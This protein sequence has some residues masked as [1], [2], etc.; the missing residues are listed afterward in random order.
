MKVFPSKFAAR[1]SCAVMTI[2]IFPTSAFA[3]E[4]DRQISAWESS[5]SI[6]RNDIVT[7][8]VARG[9]D[10]LDS[11]TSTSSIKES[12]LGRLTPRTLAEL[13]R[14]IPGIRVEASN[15]EG[16]NNYAVRGLPLVGEGAKYVQIQE[17]G[18]PVLEFGDILSSVAD[19]FVRADF[20]VSQVESI[21]GGSSS[22]FASNAPGGVINL[23]SK[24][25]DVQ[26]GSIQQTVGIDYGN[27]R[28][29]FDYGSNLGDGWRFHVGGFYRGG[30]GPRKTGLASYRGGQAKINI[31]K[32]FTDGYV[33]VYAKFL[34]D[35][36][37][38]YYFH[39][40]AVGGTNSEPIYSTVNNF[41]ALHNSVVSP[42]IGL[43]LGLDSKGSVIS[44]DFRDGARAKAATLGFEAQVKL[45]DW[46]VTD[47]FRYSA[48]SSAHSNL[49]TASAAPA[50]S[51]A[52]AIG[53][54]GA[55]LTYASGPL[56]GQP[57]NSTRGSGLLALSVGAA[58]DNPDLNYVT[59]DLRISRVWNVAGGDLTTT[60]GL[61][62][63]NQNLEQEANAT[64]FIHDVVDNGQ[65]SLININTSGGT[66]VTQ[67][68]VL[69]FGS[70]AP[71][72]RVN[73]NVSYTITAPFGSFNFHKGRFA[74]GGSA[75]VDTGK[76]RGSVIND[77]GTRV[78]DLNG[79]GVI[80]L[81]EMAVTYVPVGEMNPVRYN[82]SYLSYSLGI[83]IRVSEPFAMFAR[84]SRGSRAGAE[85]IL[86]NSLSPTSG[87]LINRQAAFDP[88]KQA[89][90]GL[91]FRNG[92]LTLNLTGFYAKSDET[93][94]QAKTDPAT[95]LI[96]YGAVSRSYKA[97]G[98][99]FEGALR[100]GA[101][102]ITAGA[103]WT[104]AEII[105]AED[106]LLSGKTPRHQPA[107][108][109]QLTPQYDT[110]SF[111]FGANVI[112]TTGSFSQDV[113]QLK[114]PGY[115]TVGLFT[116]YRPIE[117]VEVSLNVSN[118][119]DKLAITDV[120]EGTI[121]SS[122]VAMA[123]TLYGRTTSASVRF[124]F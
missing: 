84:Y 36:F 108:L 47:R 114:M 15:G 78:Y 1:A 49:F 118:L 52:A 109:Y 38:A 81:P 16:N 62:R 14:T 28:T 8:G 76:V 112:G 42:F 93:S 23:I 26:G 89:E 53:G 25:G 22:T 80:S 27:Y 68:G 2:V 57:F 107:L 35:R 17:D 6:D 88:V 98:L 77:T 66:A 24:T 85:K 79:D 43:G 86:I 56:S 115:A 32:Q 30:E 46:I 7:T 54:P 3:A 41:S 100:R 18:L 5:R 45:G 90:V 55:Q 34:D 12:Q 51:F 21:R 40:I 87:N 113:N 39:P 50:A 73:S 69:I 72:S 82:Y 13:F 64:T 19:V 105:K 83:N 110:H 117:K 60:A 61:Y 95:Q 92:G 63:S 104:K 29:D 120:L 123:R 67:S 10:R 33:R 101:F 37:P 96:T 91:K 11:A 99:E 121:P 106:P 74:V 20:N 48:L 122:G 103:T 71:G 111:S 116:Q 124:Y 31:T 70:P 44:H 9:R 102:A 58:Y 65:S 119:F 75:R 97:Y 4:D 59:N 94:S